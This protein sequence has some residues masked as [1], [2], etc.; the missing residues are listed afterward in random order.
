[1]I[2]LR[3]A[4]VFLVMTALLS[5][6]AVWVPSRFSA[7]VAISAAGALLMGLLFLAHWGLE[8]ISPAP[9]EPFIPPGGGRPP[10]AAGETNAGSKRGMAG[11][12]PAPKPKPQ[13]KPRRAA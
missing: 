4:A 9:Y 6:L 10:D 8:K 1:M 11:G 7:V 13:P 12:K 5:L 2:A 3:A